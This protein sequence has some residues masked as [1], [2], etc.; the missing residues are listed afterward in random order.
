[1]NLRTAEEAALDYASREPRWP[2]TLHV[3][4]FAWADRKRH[5]RKVSVEFRKRAASVARRLMDAAGRAK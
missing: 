1:M 2:A 3:Q 5:D 4:A